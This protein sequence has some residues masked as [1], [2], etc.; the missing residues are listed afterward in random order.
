MRFDNLGALVLA[1]AFAVPATGYADESELI[2]FN[3]KGA[4][5]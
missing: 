1:V 5:A 2:R 3:F 4:C